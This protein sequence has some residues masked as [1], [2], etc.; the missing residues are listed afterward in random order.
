MT[1]MAVIAT[2]LVIATLLVIADHWLVIADS[3]RNPGSVWHWI[4]DQGRDDNL[5]GG[6]P[7]L[8]P[9]GGDMHG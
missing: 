3:I 1:G 6:Q 2:P 4:P 8:F 9:F 5:G 7:P